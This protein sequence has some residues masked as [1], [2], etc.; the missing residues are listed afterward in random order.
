MELQ[1]W[2]GQGGQEK[3]GQ[4]SGKT[5]ENFREGPSTIQG[6]T[7]QLGSCTLPGFTGLGLN[8]LGYA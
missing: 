4:L 2:R 1:V 7:S 3:R 6:S 5:P 8:L